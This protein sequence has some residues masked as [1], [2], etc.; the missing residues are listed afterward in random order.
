[1]VCVVAACSGAGK[2]TFMEKLIKSL[3][4]RGLKVCAVKHH[5]G[6]LN[7]DVPGKDTWRHA[8]AGA[9]T[10]LLST[11]EGLGMIKR[12][13]EPSLEEIRLLAGDVDLILAEGY[14]K[15][16][17]LPKIEIIRREVC[18]EGGPVTRPEDLLA[19]VTDDSTLGYGTPGT[20]VFDLEDASGVAG[21]I[22][23]FLGVSP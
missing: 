4:Q 9:D 6:E 11:P 8:R 21:Y 14:K 7:F 19:L 10:V 1:M 12:G 16:T 15:V 23:K 13:P 18:I 20:P 3:K 17:G 22:I 2:T 5:R